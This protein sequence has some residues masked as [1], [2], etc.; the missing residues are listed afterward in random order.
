MWLAFRPT[1]VAAS[2]IA[3]RDSAVMVAPS[4][5]QEWWRSDDQLVHGGGQ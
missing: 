2:T 5:V 4:P 3:R 1:A